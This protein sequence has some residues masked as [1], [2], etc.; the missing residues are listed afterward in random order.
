M[1]LSKQATQLPIGPSRGE[2]RL[3]EL[4]TALFSSLLTVDVGLSPGLHLFL[5]RPSLAENG[6]LPRPGGAVTK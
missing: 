1:R 5:S 3:T 4:R 6:T 2:A